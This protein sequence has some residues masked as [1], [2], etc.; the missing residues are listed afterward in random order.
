MRNELNPHKSRNVSYL[1]LFSVRVLEL[2]SRGLPVKQI[3]DRLNTTLKVIEAELRA[4]RKRLNAQ[5][6]IELIINYLSLSPNIFFNEESINE[7][8]ERAE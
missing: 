3:A 2:K 8:Y 1:H 4:C 7:L 6:N 5:N